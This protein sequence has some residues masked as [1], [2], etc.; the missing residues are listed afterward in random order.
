MP[1][2]I[3]TSRTII[4]GYTAPGERETITDTTRRA[5]AT[6][7]EA[8]E[9]A[10][11]ALPAAANLSRH[12]EAEDIP[13]AGGTI[14][15]LPD[16]TVI[17]VRPILWAELARDTGQF[18]AGHELAHGEILEA[19]NHAWTPFNVSTYDSER[20]EHRARP[21]VCTVKV[22]RIVRV[23]RFATVDARDRYAAQARHDVALLAER[24]R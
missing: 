1:Y 22:G 5:V 2:V 14:G 6:L 19:F 16:G 13:A 11:E 17:G 21:Y 10:R 8:R 3:T 18:D 15:P 23:E 4:G 9:A 12:Y 24:A 20:A 7:E